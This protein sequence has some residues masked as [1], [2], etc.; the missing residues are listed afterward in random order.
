MFVHQQG[1][2]NNIFYLRYRYLSIE[3]LL[4][5]INLVNYQSIYISRI[6]E[7][8]EPVYGQRTTDIITDDN[9]STGVPELSCTISRSSSLKS[10]S[11]IKEDSDVSVLSLAHCMIPHSR[12]LYPTMLHFRG[13]WGILM[14]MILNLCA[15]EY[16]VV[17]PTLKRVLNSQSMALMKLVRQYSDITD[18]YTFIKQYI[19]DV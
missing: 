6:S 12:S 8:M 13:Q 19:H 7:C 5:L 2:T 1:V 15:V 4:S 14:L 16:R 3:Q 11:R 10:I 9:R 18:L 17:G